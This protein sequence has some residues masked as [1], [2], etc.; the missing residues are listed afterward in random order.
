MEQ[1]LIKA[2]EMIAKLEQENENLKTELAGDDARMDKMQQE[3]KLK[4]RKKTDE[5]RKADEVSEKV[6]AELG[7]KIMQLEF[8]NKKLKEENQVL[9]GDVSDLTKIIAEKEFE[10]D[11]DLKEENETLK[12]E[13]AEWDRQLEECELIPSENVLCSYDDIHDFIW[14]QL[15]QLSIDY[16]NIPEFDWDQLFRDF[17]NNLENE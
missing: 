17:S 14:L 13:N 11:E 6:Y 15:K 10:L 8:E 16:P 4:L 3:F 9:E 12:A 7:L 1:E 5:L 2:K